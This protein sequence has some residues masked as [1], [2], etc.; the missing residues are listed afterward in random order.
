MTVWRID[1]L[2]IRFDIV[3]QILEDIPIFLWCDKSYRIRDI[4]I[5]RTCINS[6]LNNLQKEIQLCSGRIFRREFD[7]FKLGTG[8]RDMLTDCFQN[9][10]LALIEFILTVNRTGSDKDVNLWILGVLESLVTSINIRLDRAS[11]TSYRCFL[12][13]FSNLLHCRK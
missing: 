6:C 5:R 7:N 3:N 1:N 8:I 9:L 11:Q 12:Q 4:D 13:Y 10:F 2:T